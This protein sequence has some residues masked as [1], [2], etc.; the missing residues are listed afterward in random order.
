MGKLLTNPNFYHALTSFAMSA[1]IVI[2]PGQM[3]NIIAAGMAV[4]G[5]L[6]VVT[7]VRNHL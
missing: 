1:G 6:H 5:V 4:S 2:G 7:V 3:H